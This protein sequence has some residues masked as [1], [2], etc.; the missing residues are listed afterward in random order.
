MGTQTSKKQSE[1]HV[2]AEAPKVA[3]TSLDRAQLELKLQRDR[4]MAAIRRYEV[5]AREERT[6]AGDFLRAGNRRKAL[7]C[8][9]RE[10]IQQSQI[11]SVTDM[12]DNVQRVLDTVEFSQIEVEVL[13][14]LKGGKDELS[15]LNALLNVDD[16]TELMD[17]TA[18]TIEEARRINNVLAQPLAGYEDEDALLAELVSQGPTNAFA[19]E[20]AVENVAI[21]THKLAKP[22]V[23]EGHATEGASEKIGLAA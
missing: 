6:K 21:P 19:A 3:V 10:K 5:V 1:R 12:L 17:D 13:D 2:L 4:L 14:A 8:L 22:T 23:V 18:E 11:T 20:V 9:K 7:Y 15:K 16:I